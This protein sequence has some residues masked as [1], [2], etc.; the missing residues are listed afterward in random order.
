[1]FCDLENCL[2]LILFLVILQ[3]QQYLLL[4]QGTVEPTGVIQPH[5]VMPGQA[6]SLVPLQASHKDASAF[7]MNNFRD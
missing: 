5:H 4:L 2:C 3:F 1:M 6:V 7:N